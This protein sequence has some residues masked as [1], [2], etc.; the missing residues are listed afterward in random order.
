MK[1]ISMQCA[2]ILLLLMAAPPLVWADDRADYN[3]RV[4]A[5]L[6][7][8]FQTLDRNADGRLTLDEARGNLD[9]GPRFN[10]IDTNRDGIMTREELR[11]YI[12]RRY[13]SQPAP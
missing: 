2:G 9:L 13:G 4:A 6:E 3:A 12:Q 8:L 7:S 11:V 1:P 10:D 5:R